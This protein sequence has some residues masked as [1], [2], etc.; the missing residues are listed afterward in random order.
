MAH[1]RRRRVVSSRYERREAIHVYVQ[2]RNCHYSTVAKRLRRARRV[3]ICFRPSFARDAFSVFIWRARPVVRAVSLRGGVSDGRTLHVAQW[4]HKHDDS[5]KRDVV[6]YD[7]KPRPNV[8]GVVKGTVVK[9]FRYR[10]RRI[11]VFFFFFYRSYGFALNR[12]C[13]FEVEK[14]RINAIR[15]R[16]K[17][18]SRDRIRCTFP[19]TSIFSKQNVN[20]VVFS[21]NVCVWTPHS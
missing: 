7:L 8:Y 10:S 21:T 17:G 5:G 13:L 19:C 6:N 12:G 18:S 11:D 2:Q 15:N 20:D 3:F 14:N 4:R 9:Q 16:I 1:R